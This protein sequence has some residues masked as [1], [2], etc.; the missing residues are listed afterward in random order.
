M[1]GI[2]V[3][4]VCM[5]VCVNVNNINTPFGIH[6]Y[7]NTCTYRKPYKCQAI[8][9]LLGYIM[10]EIAKQTTPLAMGINNMN[11]LKH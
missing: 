6:I 5:R 4:Y 7:M 11:G 9:I 8:V 1:G 10:R 2:S 3:R